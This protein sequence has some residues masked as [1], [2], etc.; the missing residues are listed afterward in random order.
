MTTW[1]TGTLKRHPDPLESAFNYRWKFS[2]NPDREEDTEKDT[3]Q[4]I[5]EEEASHVKLIDAYVTM[6]SIIIQVEL[7]SLW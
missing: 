2:N 7:R 5:E 4:E 1:T 3:K 6:K